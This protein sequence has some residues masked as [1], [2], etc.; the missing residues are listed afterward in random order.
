MEILVDIKWLLGIMGFHKNVRSADQRRDYIHRTIYS[1]G[2]VLTNISFIWFILD[3]P[4]VIMEPLFGIANAFSI[5]AI[6]FGFV[7]QCD[8]ILELFDELQLKVEERKTH[9]IFKI[10]LENTHKK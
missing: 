9:N 2:L 6:Y 3:D 4:D 1:V 7:F 8:R 5:T 10:K